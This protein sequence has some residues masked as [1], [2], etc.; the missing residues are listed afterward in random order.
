ADAIVHCDKGAVGAERL[1]HRAAE[2]LRLL[3]EGLHLFRREI[4]ESF[5]VRPRN[6]EHVP[7]KQRPMVEKCEGT[8]VLLNNWG[9]DTSRGDLAEG[10]GRVHPSI[11][12]PHPGR[13]PAAGGLPD[14]VS[15]AGV[16]HSEMRRFTGP[17]IPGAA[18]YHEK[19]DPD[20][21]GKKR[22]VR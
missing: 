13:R 3:K 18:C 12:P 20:L 14:A 11:M 6:Q 8:L 7:G 19:E 21:G 22:W 1:L 4:G 9:G 2:R 16:L 10:A 15:D 5:E 17:P